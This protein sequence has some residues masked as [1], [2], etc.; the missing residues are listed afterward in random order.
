MNCLLLTMFNQLHT[1]DFA[2]RMQY[3]A[4]TAIDNVHMDNIR[5]NLSS[6][7]PIINGLSDY[8][9]W[10][11]TVKNIY[12]TVHKVTLKQRTRLI[13]NESHELSDSTK[14]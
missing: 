5:L 7:S 11:L 4:S 8:G 1:V 10:I 3:N 9:P 6:P 13:N 2:M 12:A 14:K